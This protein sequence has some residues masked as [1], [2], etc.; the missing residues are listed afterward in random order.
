MSRPIPPEVITAVALAALHPETI[1][2]NQAEFTRTC[3]ALGL[4]PGA[5]RQIA[6]QLQDMVTDLDCSLY[7][8]NGSARDALRL[9]RA[10][11]DGEAA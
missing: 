5:A 6:V 11:E 9:V 10:Q 3:A 1:N 4:P 2:L 7:D 8:W